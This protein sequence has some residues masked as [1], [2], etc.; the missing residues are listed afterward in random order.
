VEVKELTISGRKTS[1]EPEFC[2]TIQKVA[3]AGGHIPSMMK[4]VGIKSKATWYKWQRDFPEFKDAVEEAELLSQAFY[5]ELGLQGMMG[6][7]PNFNA[8][9]YIFMMH[10]KFNTE[11][12]RNPTATE[13]NITNNTLNLSSDQ[14]AQKIAQKLEKLKTLGIDIEHTG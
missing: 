5:E 14:M 8:T 2:E 11:Y 4:A 7:I 3:S 6:K 12:K 9:T 13:V 1:Y 10:N